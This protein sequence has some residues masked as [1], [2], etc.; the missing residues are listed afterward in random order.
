MRKFFG[1]VV[2]IGIALLVIAGWF[3][4]FQWRPSEIRKYCHLDA[5]IAA[6]E[7]FKAQVEL[8]PGE[9][10]DRDLAE[11]GE[12]MYRKDQYDSYYQKC[13]HKKGLE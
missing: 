12:G 2:F 4:W 8:A 5:V 6:M 9:P 3:Y 13:F 11:I 7:L 10:S 1:K